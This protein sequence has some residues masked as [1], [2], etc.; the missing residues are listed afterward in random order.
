MDLSPGCHDIAEKYALSM[1]YVGVESIPQRFLRAIGIMRT[2]SRAVDQA[3]RESC[4]FV[5]P[6]DLIYRLVSRSAFQDGPAVYHGNN[7]ASKNPA[8]S[9][10]RNS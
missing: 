10:F 2:N 8:I 9:V 6:T 1:R 3:K 5:Q 7:K 4:R